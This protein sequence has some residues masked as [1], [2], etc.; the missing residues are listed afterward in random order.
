MLIVSGQGGEGDRWARWLP[1]GARLLMWICFQRKG[2]RNDKW[3]SLVSGTANSYL[4]ANEYQGTTQSTR[5]V[6]PGSACEAGRLARC[7]SF[8]QP[9]FV[10]PCFKHYGKIQADSFRCWY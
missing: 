2:R 1:G 9:K 10:C 5:R 6:H 7:P 4:M 3:P 8:G